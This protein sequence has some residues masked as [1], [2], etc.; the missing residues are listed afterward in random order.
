M[1]RNKAKLLTFA[2]IFCCL[3]A[4]ILLI[5]N[6]FETAEFYFTPPLFFV[7]GIVLIIISLAYYTEK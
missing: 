4:L 6:A 1:S 7:G 3:C 2:G 5:S